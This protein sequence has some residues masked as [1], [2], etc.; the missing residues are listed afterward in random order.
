M[1]SRV[2]TICIQTVIVLLNV[3]AV[4]AQKYSII[5]VQF[6]CSEHKSGFFIQTGKT[7]THK[8]CLEAGC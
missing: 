2:L 1:Y 3:N 6:E 5:S 8:S 4:I 7:R